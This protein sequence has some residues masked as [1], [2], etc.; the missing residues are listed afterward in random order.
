M[1]YGD[2]W[3]PV[4]DSDNSWIQTGDGGRWGHKR[5]WTHSELVDSKPDWGTQGL[6]N[7]EGGTG[8]GLCCSGHGK[9]NIG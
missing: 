6:E 8:R 3:A 2:K 9:I 5:C 7:G 1:T 4:S